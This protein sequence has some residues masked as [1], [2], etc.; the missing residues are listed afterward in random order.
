MFSQTPFNL[1]VR[2]PEGILSFTRDDMLGYAG[3]GQLIA[4]G[5]VMRLFSRAFSDLCPG[6][7][8]PARSDIR[9]LTAFPGKGVRDCIEL[10]TRAVTEGRFI[11]DTEAA[12]A[13]APTTPVGGAMYY[14]VAY[15]G[16]AFAYT[17]SPDIFDD[18]WRAEV[19]EY[20]NGAERLED[21]AR[22]V[23][24]KYQVLGELMNRPD[25]FID[26]RPCSAERLM[27][28]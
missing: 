10:V 12:P 23:G 5:V 2:E 7:D 4:S 1:C 9:V 6:G 22:Y 11:L 15:R 27:A 16:K 26:V 14:E 18:Q 24:Y 28:L 21:H 25:V 20:T 3:L 13:F 8:V 19:A 17:F